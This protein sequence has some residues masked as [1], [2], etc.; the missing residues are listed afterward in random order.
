MTNEEKLVDWMLSVA[1]AESTDCI[2]SIAEM[3]L[4]LRHALAKHLA[5]AKRI[6]EIQ[7][8]FLQKIAPKKRRG[9]KA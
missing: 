5:V 3:K 7:P 2:G 1:R 8:D 6:L 9:R 4:K